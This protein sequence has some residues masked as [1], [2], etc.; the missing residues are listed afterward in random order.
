MNKD[1]VKFPEMPY[2]YIY[3]RIRSSEPFTTNGVPVPAEINAKAS[4]A[5]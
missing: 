1:T 2:L 3:K 4:L 5:A